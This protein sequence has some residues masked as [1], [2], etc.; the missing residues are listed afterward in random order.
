[1]EDGCLELT[2]P[3]GADMM[4]LSPLLS[5]PLARGLGLCPPA[6]LFGCCTTSSFLPAH[7]NPEQ[8]PCPRRQ[9]RCLGPWRDVQL[10]AQPSR[11]ESSRGGLASGTS[12]LLAASPPGP[13]AFLGA[14]PG[15]IPPLASQGQPGCRPAP[16][17]SS[18]GHRGCRP[19]CIHPT[20]PL[21]LGFVLPQLHSQ[22]RHRQ[23]PCAPQHSSAQ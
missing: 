12:A 14:L 5:F 3:H 19:R 18:W 20:Q 23:P 11:A 8:P 7:S 17:G 13:A 2:S 6:I 16:T 21:S 15:P 22:G 1:M 10:H 9:L 4:L